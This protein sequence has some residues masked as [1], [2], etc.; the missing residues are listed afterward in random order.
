MR[1]IIHDPTY[2]TLALGTLLVLAVGYFAAPFHEPSRLDRFFLSKLSWS[3]CADVVLAGDSRVYQGLSPTLMS[4]NH[5]QLR[6]AN[7][8]F[9]ACGYGEEYLQGIQRVLDEN[10]SQRTIVLGVTPRSL[11]AHACA[12][13][14]YLD[15]RSRYSRAE[16]F[17][18]QLAQPLVDFCR[19]LPTR[20]IRAALKDPSSSRPVLV[21]VEHEDGWL[22]CSS[23]NASESET[24]RYYRKHFKKSP[25]DEEIV[26]R[27]LRQVRA[28][29][30]RG[31]RVYAYR[32]PASRAL[33]EVEDELSGFDEAAFRAQLVSAGGTW[34]EIPPSDYATYDGS[35][36]NPESARRL[37]LDLAG[38]MSDSSVQVA[39]RDEGLSPG[40]ATGTY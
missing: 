6:I 28:W 21:R 20:N 24:V 12:V 18:Y 3:D 29:S 39:E 34:I 26:A 7:F 11:T 36:L 13:N 40:R 16:L 5:L 35:H 4:D 27:L 38:A 30:A 2:S 17:K 10:S 31:I 32:P 25:V 14:G 1:R 15:C 22:E 33:L 8:G 37:S 9:S 19:Q 23:P